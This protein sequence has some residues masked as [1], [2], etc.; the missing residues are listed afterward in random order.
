MLA[1]EQGEAVRRKYKRLKLGG[2]Q[3]YELSGG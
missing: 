1:I 2:G 3:A